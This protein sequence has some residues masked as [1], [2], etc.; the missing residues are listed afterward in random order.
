MTRA[1]GAMAVVLIVGG[2][3]LA[4]RDLR[5][6]SAGPHSTNDPDSLSDPPNWKVESAGS[7]NAGRVRWRTNSSANSPLPTRYGV[8]TSGEPP[9]W[10]RRTDK[11]PAAAAPTYLPKNRT[12]DAPHVTFLPTLALPPSPRALR[13]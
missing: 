10:V 12:I 6:S 7:N 9:L 1:I 5:P 13:A 11:V 3:S 2:L 4:Y 8:P